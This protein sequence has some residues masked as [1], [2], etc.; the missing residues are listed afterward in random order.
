M[1][2][3]KLKL[4]D[5][6]AS[7]TL[8]W[9][10]LWT[11]LCRIWYT[12]CTFR[13]YTVPKNKVI[14]KSMT[15]KHVPRQFPIS[16]LFHYFRTASH[17]CVVRNRF[18]FSSCRYVMEEWPKSRYRCASCILETKT[19]VGS[20]GAKAPAPH[21]NPNIDEAPTAPKS[22]THPSHEYDGR[23]R[24]PEATTA[25]RHPSRHSKPKPSP[26]RRRPLPHVAKKTLL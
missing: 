2:D 22:H 20:T 10:R 11:L 14:I 15:L 26:G 13:L 7:H 24:D 17:T 25:R 23:T 12:F 9:S 6:R 18:H 19:K 16:T 21:T 4:R 8:G 1:K 5:L 3:Y